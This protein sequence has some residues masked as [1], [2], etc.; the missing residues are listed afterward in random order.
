M[1][2]VRKKKARSPCADRAPVPAAVAG[3]CVT[4]RDLPRTGRSTKQT[5]SGR[6]GVNH[7]A[8]AA[9]GSQRLSNTDGTASGLVTVSRPMSFVAMRCASTSI[10]AAPSFTSR[11]LTGKREE[12]GLL[13]RP[14]HPEFVPQSIH[15]RATNPPAVPE[16]SLHHHLATNSANCFGLIG[17]HLGSPCAV[18]QREEV[19]SAGCGECN[20]AIVLQQ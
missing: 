8:A 16:R 1:T 5:A 14:P 4:A 15:W 2:A 9:A 3:Q 18:S 10:L 13:T 19:I 11:R 20:R 7:Q 17:F 12:L 6:P